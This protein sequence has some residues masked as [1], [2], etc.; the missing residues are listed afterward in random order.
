MR[1]IKKLLCLSF[2]VVILC[3]LESENALIPK[4]NAIRKTGQLSTLEEDTVLTNTALRYSEELFQIG[5]LTHTDTLGN[6][7][8]GR[9][10]E[11]GGT[12]LRVGEIL[13]VGTEVD[14]IITAWL[15]SASHKAVMLNPQWT[16]C[17]YG[18]WESMGLK[19]IVM[20]FIEKKITQLLITH[21]SN[22]V[23]ITGYSTLPYEFLIALY[24]ADKFYQPVTWEQSTRFFEFRIGQKA[25]V[26][27]ELGY[28]DSNNQFH[29]TDIIYPYKYKNY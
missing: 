29:S 15:E 16:H 7:A 2:S 10:R 12:V 25:P 4:I 20:L 28:L 8:L 9:Y 19:I 24:S 5:K 23:T 27:L 14:S 18:I 3:H 13:G 1:F 21:T 26:C 22:N 17:G 11:Q 6:K